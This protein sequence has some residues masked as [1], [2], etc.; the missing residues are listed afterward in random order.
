MNL[1]L[2]LQLPFKLPIKDGQKIISA[3]KNGEFVALF[4]TYSKPILIVESEEPPIEKDVTVITLSYLPQDKVIEDMSHDELLRHTVLSSIHYINSFLDAIR[5]CFG[6]NY[7]YNITISDLPLFLLISNE[8]ED[9]LYFTQS[10]E[11]SI[12]KENLS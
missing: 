10:Q 8:Q 2:D 5:S 3:Y 12:S 6:L 4:N 7:I 9:F 11:I 1:S